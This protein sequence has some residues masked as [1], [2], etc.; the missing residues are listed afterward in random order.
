LARSKLVFP[1]TNHDAQ[2]C[3]KH[4]PDTRK[5]TKKKKEKKNLQRREKAPI[6]AALTTPRHLLRFPALRD[7]PEKGKRDQPKNNQ[8]PRKKKKYSKKEQSTNHFE[9]THTQKPSILA[10][11]SMSTLNLKLNVTNQQSP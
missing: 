1:H 2:T 9:K 5:N 4:E 8:K 10:E 11:E 6:Q 7:D 3:R